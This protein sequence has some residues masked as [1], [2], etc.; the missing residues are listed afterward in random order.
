ML[1]QRFSLAV[2]TES[3]SLGRLIAAELGD[4]VVAWDMFLSFLDVA[5][6]KATLGS[7]I[8]SVKRLAAASD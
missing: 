2:A 6:W 7:L 3:A 5:P 4:D 8:T 1:S